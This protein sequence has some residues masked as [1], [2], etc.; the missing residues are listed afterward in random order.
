MGR[1]D[2]ETRSR[3]EVRAHTRRV[4]AAERRDVRCD[5]HDRAVMPLERG[6]GRRDR[7]R[8]ERPAGRQLRDPA[9]CVR[10]QLAPQALRAAGADGPIER[11]V[12]RGAERI[13]DDG[14][15]RR[16]VVHRS[17]PVSPS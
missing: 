11:P 17:P 3:G 12:E 9:P 14:G 7:R 8:L 15:D 13:D 2:D 4:L 1:G 6:R 16:V 5:E 10:P